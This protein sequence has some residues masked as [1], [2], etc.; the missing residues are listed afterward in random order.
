MRLACPRLHAHVSYSAVASM[1]SDLVSTSL[2]L[3]VAAVA[4]IHVRK[5]SCLDDLIL[6]YIY[7]VPNKDCLHTGPEGRTSETLLLSDR[8]E[9]DPGSDLL[10]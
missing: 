9:S 10:G 4:S 6:T 1:R 8:A 5:R 3:H 2:L 7:Q